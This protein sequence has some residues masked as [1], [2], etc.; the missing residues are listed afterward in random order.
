MKLRQKRMELKLKKELRDVFGGG[1]PVIPGI[2]EDVELDTD[3]LLAMEEKLTA[4]RLKQENEKILKTLEARKKAIGMDYYTP[5]SM[6]VKAHKSL[7]RTILVCAGNRS[8]KSHCG[9][10][11]LCFHLTRRYPDWYPEKKRFKKPIKAVISCNS[12]S[13]AL[14]VIESKLVSL[15][16]LG[17]YKI[18]RNPQGYPSR[19]TCK[20]GSTVDILTLEMSDQMYESAD[21]DFAWEDEPQQQRKREAIFRGLTDRRGLEIITFTPITEPWM[22]EELIDKA[23]GKKIELITASIRDNLEDIKGNKILSAEAVDEFEASLSEEFKEARMFGSFYTLRGRVYKEFNEAAHVKQFSYQDSDN[24]GLPVICVLDPHDRRPHHLI[25]AFV[26]RTDDIYVVKELQIH[27]ELPD[28][29]KKIK[30]LEKEENYYVKRRFIDPNFGRKPASAG[31]NRSVIQELAKYGVGFYEA[32]DDIELG[33]MIVRDY[34]HYDMSKEITA[35]NKPKIFFHNTDCPKTIRS[36]R[37]LQFEEWQGK[38]KGERSSK[39]AEKDRDTDGA[40]CVRYLCI[41]RPRYENLTFKSES[42]ELTGAPY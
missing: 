9:A 7:C 30:A 39:E 18:K 14:K 17:Y 33:H 5:N 35:F 8:G 23:D 16:P 28:L 12:F 2:G 1:P 31:N 38:T 25:W 37:N 41:G 10:M 21:W 6:Q 42:L 11:E 4:E 32:Q 19:I 3:S 20:D 27:C 15:L 13:T 36:V 29:A 34:L 22:K 26:D 40:D 24:L